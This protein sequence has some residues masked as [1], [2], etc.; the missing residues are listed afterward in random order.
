MHRWRRIQ[1]DIGRK[2]YQ[3]KKSIFLRLHGTT[4]K[5]V[6][7]R[8][9]EQTRHQDTKTESTYLPSS[10]K[11]N[12]DGGMSCRESEMTSLTLNALLVSRQSEAGIFGDKKSRAL[13]LSFSGPAIVHSFELIANIYPLSSTHRISAIHIWEDRSQPFGEIVVP[14]IDQATGDEVTNAS[15]VR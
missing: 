2:E 5:A 14:S 7:S 10:I 3:R 4:I 8:Y 13:I 9:Y 11:F 1:V 6:T 12:A 15:H